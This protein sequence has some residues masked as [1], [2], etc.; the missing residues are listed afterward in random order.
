[1]LVLYC[2]SGPRL[3]LSWT[4]HA[5][6]FGRG[7]ELAVLWVA[8]DENECCGDAGE[9]HYGERLAR[10][11]CSD[12][13]L[14]FINGRDSG[15]AVLLLQPRLLQL[16][17]RISFSCRAY[18]SSSRFEASLL[19]LPRLLQ[20]FGRSECEEVIDLHFLGL[21]DHA[22]TR[23]A[24]RKRVVSGREHGR[25][26]GWQAQRRDRRARQREGQDEVSQHRR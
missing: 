10:Q 1:M 2:P 6:V 12:R 18:S 21:I 5:D 26:G 24:D 20:L 8:D 22:G 19:V 14:S 17:G 3:S 15:E 13:D 16:L 25:P 9:E 11:R 4:S 23:V 7:Q